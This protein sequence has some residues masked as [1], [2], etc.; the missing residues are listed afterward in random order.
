MRASTCESP[1]SKDHSR[2]PAQATVLL[3]VGDAGTALATAYVSAVAAEYTASC[4]VTRTPCAGLAAGATT[5]ALEQALDSGLFTPQLAKHAGSDGQTLCLAPRVVCI[6][7]GGSEQ[8]ATTGGEADALP[9]RLWDATWAAARSDARAAE[10]ALTSIEALVRRGSSRGCDNGGNVVFHL[11]ADV[12]SPSAGLLSVLLPQLADAYPGATILVTPLCAPSPSLAAASG[13]P[14]GGPA[15][16]YTSV[17]TWS[18][19]AEHSTL[20]LGLDTTALGDAAAVD[21]AASVLC[22][23]TASHRSPRHGASLQQLA[24]A[25]VPF[26]RLH[27]TFPSIVPLARIGSCYCDSH[28]SQQAVHQRYGP[29]SAL[30]TAR[31]ACASMVRQLFDPLSMLF[32]P[33]VQASKHRTLGTSPGSPGRHGVLAGRTLAQSAVL[34][35]APDPWCGTWPAEIMHGTWLQDVDDN[36]HVPRSLF[37]APLLPRMPDASTAAAVTGV[38]FT[39]TAAV[40]HMLA[41]HATAAQLALQRGVAL[42][43]LLADG[44]SHADIGDALAD[45]A[46]WGE[47]YA[48]VGGGPDGSGGGRPG[49]ATPP[50]DSVPHTGGGDTRTPVSGRAHTQGGDTGWST[51]SLAGSFGVSSR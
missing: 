4:G 13:T 18:V 47:E 43:A 34:R 40:S 21:M 10:W 41:A 50:V 31:L 27:V 35:M 26:P 33:A 15:A 29:G 48:E 49:A 23:A 45:V 17:M 3:A 39:N 8:G 22:G 19:I 24:T 36:A 16:A 6:P 9:M 42:H 51:R 20:T 25:L 28:H 38:G 1:A 32:G 30:W 7:S 11:L 5:V 12:F 2:M 44:M 37:T 14:R 46:A